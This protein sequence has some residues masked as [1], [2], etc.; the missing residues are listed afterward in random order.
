MPDLIM[1]KSHYAFSPNLLPV[2]YLEAKIGS[3]PVTLANLTELTLQEYKERFFEFLKPYENI[4]LYTGRAAGT[5]FARIHTDNRSGQGGLPTLGYGFNLANKAVTYD[6]IEKAYRYAINRSSGKLSDLQNTALDILKEWKTPESTKYSNE[7]IIDLSSDKPSS[8]WSNNQTTS[9]KSLELS[10]AQATRL[11]DFMIFKNIGNFPGA[12][13]DAL[14]SHLG[15]NSSLALSLE[16]VGLLS[17]FYNANILIGADV[18]T[19][20]AKNNRAGV[21]ASIRYNTKFTDKNGKV[22]RGQITRR[23]AETDLIG[24][25]TRDP[26]P[27][28]DALQEAKLALDYLFTGT[29]G[30]GQSV[31]SRIN[32]R[33]AQISSKAGSN[34]GFRAEIRH[35]LD[36]ISNEYGL[37]KPLDRIDVD[38]SSGGVRLLGGAATDIKH[39]LAN[40]SD[41]LF[42]EVGDDTID[43]F[44]GDDLLVGGNGNDNL[45]GNTGH[46]ILIGGEGT[47]TL[48]GGPG[49]DILTGGN[50]KDR[51]VFGPGRDIITDFSQSDE[52]LDFENVETERYSMGPTYF[53]S[54]KYYFYPSYYITRQKGFEFLNLNALAV[55]SVPS[56]LS[57]RSVLKSGGSVGSFKPYPGFNYFILQSEHG[58]NSSLMSGFFASTDAKPHSVRVIGE[59]NG[60]PVAE[61]SFV[62]EYAKSQKIEFSSDFKDLNRVKFV[63]DRGIVMDDLVIRRVGGGERDSIVLPA[64]ATASQLIDS[65]TMDSQGNAILSWQG[66][67]LTLLGV[68]RNE[69]STDFFV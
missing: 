17:A 60:R 29:F 34:N 42:G 5:S 58:H 59:A 57:A 56:E 14:T 41:G 52:V 22:L 21:W 51:F 61:Q 65:S 63:L 31:Y 12:Y 32:Q 15:A 39:T 13:D 38:T 62:V 37:S 7:N 23:V 50:G 18:K 35:L 4:N 11:L 49:N 25:S 40:T 20:I 47:D 68:R 8:S 55:D 27:W 53:T 67:S 16:R 6:L 36:R 46:D 45:I 2:G 1:M 3:P 69:L 10:D 26:L 24:L 44:G 30:S 48:S 54:S 64:G 19:A 28:E 66:N 43:G 33:D 9:M